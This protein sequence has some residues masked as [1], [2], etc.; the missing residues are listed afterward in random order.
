LPDRVLDSTAR[1]TLPSAPDPK[2]KPRK[3][4]DGIA[5][6]P[7]SPSVFVAFE[8]S[9]FQVIRDLGKTGRGRPKGP[10][11]WSEGISDIEGK[12]AREAV[13]ECRQRASFNGDRASGRHGSEARRVSKTEFV[14]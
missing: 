14:D 10:R 12:A 9:P 11:Q 4:S 7:I 8:A 2:V 13:S 1:S 3:R 6:R 5:L